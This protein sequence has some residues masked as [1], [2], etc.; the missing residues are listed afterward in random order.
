MFNCGYALGVNVN[1][2]LAVPAGSVTAWEK[3]MFPG[4]I[5]PLSVPATL[6]AVGLDSS[7]VTVSAAVL[8]SALTLVCTCGNLTFTGPLF[9]IHASRHTPSFRSAGNGYQSTKTIP[10]SLLAGPMISSAT[11]LDPPIT[12]T[13]VMSYS[14][15]VYAPT[16]CVLLA[17]CVPFTQRLAR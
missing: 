6:D 14:N 7:A 5:V 1:T 15:A 2:W 12:A 3:V 13:L 10:R 9:V 4:V 11:A 16:I 17:I 8:R